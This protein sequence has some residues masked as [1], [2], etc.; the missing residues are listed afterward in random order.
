MVRNYANQVPMMPM[1]QMQPMQ[2]VHPG[3][4]NLASQPSMPEGMVMMCMNAGALNSGM[5]AAS[6]GMHPS[7]YAMLP[8]LGLPIQ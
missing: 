2:F 5:L 8:N 4:Y 7:Q 6:N 1:Q 3:G